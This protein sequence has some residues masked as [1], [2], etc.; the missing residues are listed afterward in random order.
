MEER[1]PPG[2]M[3]SFTITL[4]HTLPHQ[5]RGP[6]THPLRSG[7]PDSTWSDRDTA[8]VS[9]CLGFRREGS[10]VGVRQAG[11]C[12]PRCRGQRTTE[13]AAC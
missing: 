2:H 5:A 6:C 3:L 8:G 7:W 9:T 13:E 12:G 10:L 1:C 4:S 11:A